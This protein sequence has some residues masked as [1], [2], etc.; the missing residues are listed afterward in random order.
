MHTISDS[1]HVCQLSKYVLEYLMFYSND[2]YNI[3]YD[4]HNQIS[5]QK[6]FL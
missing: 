5:D 1:C 2:W 3:T 6:L 4:F